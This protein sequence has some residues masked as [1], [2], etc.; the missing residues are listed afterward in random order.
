MIRVNGRGY[1][2]IPL[3]TLA[4]SAC[5]A[6]QT[7][8]AE[9]F[10]ES[11]ADT[12]SLAPAV[13]AFVRG[14]EIRCLW[15]LASRCDF[16]G[17]AYHLGIGVPPDQERAVGYFQRACSLGS[18]DGCAMSGVMIVELGDKARFADVL[19]IWERACDS[20]SSLGCHSA[21]V[22]LALDSHG[23]GVPRDVPRG[24]AYLAKACAARYIPSCS[25]DAVLVFELKETERYP[26]AHQQLVKSCE[27]RERETCHWLALS[28]LDGTFG[29]KDE[30]AAGRYLWT[31]CA[32]DW[33]PSCSALAYLHAKG[34]G[35]QVNVEKAKKL[36]A[37][38]C[39]LKYQP[40]CEALR[41]PERG[42]P[43]P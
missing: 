5:A 16:V 37:R 30:R 4:L 10:D 43:A 2:P 28:E 17:R 3:L 14:E 9:P 24:R 42:F 38:A 19:A 39:V 27:L 40:A 12:A 7:R 41:H 22:T 13:D 31:A 33:G 8:P 18:A 34:I 23:L 29:K 11:A 15:G 36:T 21:G 26:A 32:E 6:Q 25:L 20:G 35:T 1:L